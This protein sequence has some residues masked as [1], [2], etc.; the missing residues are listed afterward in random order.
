MLYLENERE[1][2]LFEITGI[3]R[4]EVKKTLKIILEEY[5]DV[6]SQRAYNIGNCW[7]IKHAIRLLDKT[8]VIG[9]Q[10]YQSLRKHEWIEKQVQIML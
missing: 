8:S 3:E 2:R 4:I 7:I 5:N 9:K 6:V 1:A 10:D